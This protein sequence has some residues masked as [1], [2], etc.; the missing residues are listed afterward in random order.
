MPDICHVA[1][2]GRIEYSQAWNLQSQL[3]AEIA[4][5]QRPAALLLLEHPHTYTFG[6]QGKSEN[7]LWNQAEL[8]RR[9][10]AV[11]WVDRGGDITYHGPGQL[12]GYPLLSLATQD[13]LLTGQP[14]QMDPLTHLR[15]LEMTLILAL[16]SLGVHARQIPGLTGVW[17]DTQGSQTPAKIASIG[18]KID[19][20]GIS[21]H[22]FSLNVNP[23]MTY[24]Q[25]IVACGL[26][27]TP[28]T[29]L[30]ELLDPPPSFEITCQHVIAAFEKVFNFQTVSIDPVSLLSTQLDK[31]G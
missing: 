12:V 25:G 2:L 10:I 9:G 31:K 30:A 8:K 26:K 24:W 6:R 29:S 7:L 23:D 11:H 20:R 21:R 5:G 19:A 27:D 15:R 4:A 13:L 22:G 3:S 16:D 14:V 17:I 18:V 1:L 28:S